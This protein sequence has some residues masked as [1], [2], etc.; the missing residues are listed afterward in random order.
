MVEAGEI[1][2]GKDLDD[3]FSELFP[4]SLQE[5]GVEDNCLIME[6]IQMADSHLSTV[7]QLQK[8]LK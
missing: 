8:T 3:T 7:T 2:Y 5:T 4:D 1:R 6:E